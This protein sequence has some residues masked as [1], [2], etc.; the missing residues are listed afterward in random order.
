M[1]ITT[2]VRTRIVP[3]LT[4]L[5]VGCAAL[6]CAVWSVFPYVSEQFESIRATLNS[7]YLHAPA[8][9]LAWA[10]ALAMLAVGLWR[11][12]RAAWWVLTGL[13][14]V[15]LGAHAIR[16]ADQFQLSVGISFGIA[17]GVLAAVVAAQPL[18]PVHSRR[19]SL[20]KSATAA[21]LFA[22]LFTVAGIG[23]IAVA[24]GTLT[25]TEMLTWSASRVAGFAVNPTTVDGSVPLR[26][27][28][29]LGVLGALALIATALVIRRTQRSTNTITATDEVAVRALYERSDVRDSLAYFATR[30]DNSVVFAASGKAAVVYR[31]E[32]GVSLALGDPI[33]NQEA[34]PHAIAAW[35]KR[36]LN[37]GWTQGVTAASKLGAR[38]YRRAGLTTL[39]IA[40]ES[41]LDMTDFD[42]S[43]PALK[44]IRVA[45]N[46]LR[47][48]NVSVRVRR[49]TD[50]SPAELKAV[51][52]RARD[53]DVS[54][55]ARG[56]NRTLGRIGD[57]LDTETLLIE[58]IDG[59]NTPIA[60]M[61][62]VP[63][64]PGGATIDLLCRDESAPA[65]VTELMMS[66]LVLAS[67]ALGLDRVSFGFT[68]VHGIPTN[69]LRR[70][71]LF[72]SRWWQQDSSH[73]AN[74]HY[75]P[76]WAMRYVA[77]PPGGGLSRVA[78]A[79]GIAESRR[80]LA[81]RLSRN[82]GTR[83][84]IGREALETLLASPIPRSKPPLS[85]APIRPEHVAVRVEK[86]TTLAQSGVI[87]YPHAYQPTHSIAAA[88]NAVAGSR[89]R[90]NGRLMAWRNFGGLGFAVLRDGTGDI[91]L[92]VDANKC[93]PEKA[94]T[95]GPTFD[96][97][98]LIEVSGSLGRARKGEISLFAM[99]WRLVGK[100]LHP[101][102][103]RHKRLSSP[104]AKVRQRHVELAVNP[105]ARELARARSAVLHS[106]RNSM[107]GWDYLEAE[108]PILQTVP[109]GANARAFRT[110][111][112]VYGLELQLRTTPEL[113]LKRLCIGG[114]ERVYELGRSFRDDGSG[115]QHNPEFTVLHAFEAHVT[116][117]E[118]V[119]RCEQLVQWA[120]IAVNGQELSM[121]QRNDGVMRPFDIGGNW[122]VR[123][124]Y[125]AV[126][127]AAGEAIT[128]NTSISALRT[129]CDNASVSYRH[130]WDEGRLAY[131][132]YERIV[133]SRTELPTFYR[134]F[135]VSVS[136]MARSLD[137]DAG[138]AERCDLVAWGSVIAS[139]HTELTDPAEQRR[140][141]VLEQNRALAGD[142]D[143]MRVDDDYLE[144]LEFGMLPTAGLRVDVDRLLTLITGRTIRESLSFPFVKPKA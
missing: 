121:R 135:P 137:T 52:A 61:T 117:G 23:V 77:Y 98:D 32:L 53:W 25:G 68:D 124:F 114:L 91:Q 92:M 143:A 5:V 10:L 37:H 50:V 16:L 134:D 2:S 112:D 128:V 105:Q 33:G 24:P 118:M 12:K 36:C 96:L 81:G 31:T 111:P 104:E 35:Q 127:E 97:G 18:F 140:R 144:A 72:L 129:M 17:A 66:E 22:A 80:P 51:I 93:G 1:T 38:A 82:T 100:S 95:F 19:P 39:R 41:V 4:G 65:G 79:S 67:A 86:L 42:L 54:Q 87:S 139:A 11:A 70:M 3:R 48:Q 45:A 89:V 141:L 102:P 46:K 59:S 113:N 123:T 130:T 30:R 99:E 103:D 109:C 84:Q 76:T 56:F 142:V 14:A 69:A 126:S 116:Y 88:R 57:P 108:T 27:D 9:S 115:A 110:Q 21:V 74:G 34:W 119:T 107:A 29:L 132:L 122:P 106:V 40:S 47:K 75:G 63:W 73:R 78:I 136:P 94:A 43:S 55:T 120:A 133:V 125:D 85:A 62:L 90:I 101:L 6:S 64:A 44:P 15:I 26:T 58:A 83:T 60:M 7:Q 49:Q 131:A 28:I 71:P 13:V 20:W 8:T 138:L